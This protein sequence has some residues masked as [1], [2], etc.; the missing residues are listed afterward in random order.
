MAKESRAIEYIILPTI[1][2]FKIAVKLNVSG[3]GDKRERI[4]HKRRFK[5]IELDSRVKEIIALSQVDIPLVEEPFKDTVEKLNMD[6][7][8]FFATLNRLK[9]AGVMRRFAGI[10]NP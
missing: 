1:K 10:L 4:S 9:E 5:K 2:M 3:G 6:Y 7:D 8:E